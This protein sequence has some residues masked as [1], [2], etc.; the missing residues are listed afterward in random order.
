MGLVAP[1]HVGS[2]WTR[3]QTCAPCI[4]RQILNHCATREVPGML[5]LILLCILIVK[6]CTC[7]LLNF[8]K[9]EMPNKV[10]LAQ[11]FKIISSAYNTDEADSKY[12]SSPYHLS[13]LLKCGLTRVL[14]CVL[15]HQYG[16]WQP[17]KAPPGTEGQTATCGD[18]DSSSAMLLKKDLHQKR[19][20]WN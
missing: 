8:C 10:M 20:M 15:S 7:C 2:S 6:F 14:V 12:E 17:E 5:F 18:P 3:A 9:N 11:H 13:L 16:T 1:R 19:E 4:G